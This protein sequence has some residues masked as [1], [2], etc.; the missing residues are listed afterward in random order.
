MKKKKEKHIPG[1][2]ILEYLL[3]QTKHTGIK[4]GGK[5]KIFSTHEICHFCV[6]ILSRV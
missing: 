3:M 4:T 6:E 2:K 1:T 5:L